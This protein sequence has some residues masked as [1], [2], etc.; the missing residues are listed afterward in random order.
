MG[1]KELKK[2]IEDF[3]DNEGFPI[4]KNPKD[5]IKFSKYLILIKECSKDAQNYIPDYL[6]EIIEKNLTCLVSIKTSN[7]ETPLFNG[8]NEA[9]IDDYLNYIKNLDYKLGKGKNLASNIC[10]LKNKKDYIFFDVGEPPK[11]NFSNNY[12]SGPLSFE[13][14]IDE[15]KIITN[16]GYGSQISRKAELLSRLTSAQSTLCLN[17][18]SVTRFERNKIINSA[19]GTSIKNSFKVFD[20]SYNDETSGVMATASHNAYEKSFGYIHKR[21]IKILKKNSDLF[22]TDYII[23]KK[24]KAS[25]VIYNIRFHLYP[26][27]TAVQTMG[28]NSILLQ[29]EKNKS[30]I[31]SSSEQKISIEKSI[32]LGRNKILNNSCITIY[33]KIDNEDKTINWEI[34]RNN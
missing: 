17:D 12:Q 20:A 18:T 8:N 32:F 13:Y 21:S 30:L 7:D 5:L 34:K 15:N 14:F 10:V 28:G 33:G 4:N 11:K 19:F 23:K 31:F 27:I 1:L 29:V 24:N 3:F 22:G 6:D 25:K 16:C 2:L 9:K 26:G